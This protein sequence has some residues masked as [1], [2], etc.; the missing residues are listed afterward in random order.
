[1]PINFSELEGRGIAASVAGGA[2][3]GEATYEAWLA[4][5]NSMSFIDPALYRPHENVACVYGLFLIAVG[6]IL[7]ADSHSNHVI[8]DQPAQDYPNVNA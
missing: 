1:M 2:F 3:F 7:Y 6:G 4:F 8:D 5:R